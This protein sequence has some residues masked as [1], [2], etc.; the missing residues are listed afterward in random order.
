M[1]KSEFKVYLA[2]DDTFIRNAVIEL[3]EGLKVIRV[4]KPL[5]F[6]RK[7]HELPANVFLVVIVD[8]QRPDQDIDL[9]K[10]LSSQ[11]PDR[12]RSLLLL[13]KKQ[14]SPE[15]EHYRVIFDYVVQGTGFGKMEQIFNSLKE[16]WVH[17]CNVHGHE[18]VKTK[19]KLPG[20]VD[21]AVLDQFN[22]TELKIIKLVCQGLT[23][24][25]IAEQLFLGK[26]TVDNYRYKLIGKV[27]A[28]NTAGL[29]KFAFESGMHLS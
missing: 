7:L 4:I 16:D 24:K 17:Y 21:E 28:K 9:V 2:I 29:I 15:T 22:G 6:L 3:L 1:G 8:S 11:F 25:Q 19:V 18:P 12:T 13:T 23:S 20:T 26:S 5:H 10:T 14:P 27:G